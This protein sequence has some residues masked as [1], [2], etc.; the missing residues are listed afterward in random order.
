MH[1]YIQLFIKDSKK[2]SYKSNSLFKIE[3]MYKAFYMLKKAQDLDNEASV[4]F[5]AYM[6]TNAMIQVTKLLTIFF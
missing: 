6:N 4:F 2:M 3:Y 5:F 1:T